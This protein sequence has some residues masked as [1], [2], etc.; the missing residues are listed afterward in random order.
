MIR[1]IFGEIFGLFVDD[2]R[3]V[4]A[5]LGWLVVAGAAVYADAI[6]AAWSGFLLF[7]G[8]AA[9]LVWSTLRRARSRV[10]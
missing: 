1:R 4:L 9:I 3:F 6:P 7:A 10:R 2:G 8:L 5:Q